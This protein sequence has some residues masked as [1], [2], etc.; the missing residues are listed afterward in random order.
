MVSRFG[1][2]TDQKEYL[3]HLL[4]TPE[5]A[6][7]KDL[8]EAKMRLACNMDRLEYFQRVTVNFMKLTTRQNEHLRWLIRSYGPKHLEDAFKHGTS[9]VDAMLAA[10]IA[11]HKETKTTKRRLRVLDQY[12]S[13]L[14]ARAKAA[15]GNHQ[16]GMERPSPEEGLSPEE[17]DEIAR[18]RKTLGST[19]PTYTELL[20]NKT[21]PPPRS[22]GEY[23]EDMAQTEPAFHRGDPL[24]A[25]TCLRPYRSPNHSPE[26]SRMGATFG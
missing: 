12:I 10:Q 23:P 25:V 3:E 22:S 2:R 19:L 21:K 17:A 13:G 20:E 6:T 24:M 16:L 7:R 14:E 11:T 9:D 15:Q 8:E 4:Q 1:K 18:A 5:P 26:R